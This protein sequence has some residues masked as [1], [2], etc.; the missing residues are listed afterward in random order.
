MITMLVVITNLLVLDLG[1]IW[2][3]SGSF[4][5]E[6]AAVLHQLSTHL[7]LLMLAAPELGVHGFVRNSSYSPIHEPM[8]TVLLS[9]V[10]NAVCYS[11]REHEGLSTSGQ[12]LQAN[13]FPFCSLSQPPPTAPVIFICCI[14][15]DC[16]DEGVRTGR[17]DLQAHVP[18]F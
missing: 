5:A 3:N 8:L 4:F 18:L 2:P 9:L 17:Q 1:G 11:H 13:V 15:G 12:D 16:Q 14:A 7:W 6:A 10:V